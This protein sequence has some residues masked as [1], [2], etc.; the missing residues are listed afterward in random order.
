MLAAIEPS[1]LYFGTPVIL[2]S[3]RNPDG[4]ANLAPLSSAFWLGWRCVIGVAA[5]SKTSENL[6]R[7]GECVVNLPS[8]ELVGAVDRLALTTGSDP[9][10][11]T[12]AKRGYVHHADKFGL[13]GF[14]ALPSHTVAAPRAS[15]CPIQ[16]EAKVATR[17][18]L[19]S[20]EPEMAGAPN[21]FEL[22]VTRVHV[23]D[24]LLREGT[25]DH[26]DPV[27]WRPLIMSFQKFFG[28]GEELAPSRLATIPER[29]YRGP[30]IARARG[31]AKP[32]T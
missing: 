12:K 8:A 1:I 22:R 15:Q 26:V 20:G 10:P 4:S 21:L 16:L 19:G 9:V 14:D 30:D 24:A 6:L 17:H 13:A 28:L 7:E 27:K 25:D 5:T 31:E 3:T 32:S 29:L 18:R 11:E 23:D 2:V